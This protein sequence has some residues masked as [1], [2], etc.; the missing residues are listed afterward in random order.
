MILI[1]WPQLRADSGSASRCGRSPAPRRSPASPM[2]SRCCR[3]R[4]R[5]PPFPA[6]RI[7]ANAAAVIRSH[8]AGRHPDAG[9]PRPAPW[10][11]TRSARRALRRRLSLSRPYRIPRRAHRRAL[12]VMM[13]ASP[14]LR[15]VPVT[16]HVSLRQALDM[17]TTDAHRRRRARHRRRRCAAISASP[18]PAS[19]SPA[20]TRMPA[21]TARWAARRTTIIRP[22]IARLRP[23]ESCRHRPWPPDTMFTP[24]ARATLRCRDLHVPRPGADPAEDAR[25]DARRERDARPADRPHLARPRHRVRHRR[26]RHAPIRPA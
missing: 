22:A 25:H 3:F 5:R 9:R 13:L 11:P 24:A 6:A 4:W 16:V 10:S 7:S 2:P 8:R 20:S 17:L 15:V 1:A 21:R 23:R 14:E 18:R 26:H 12:P 19:P